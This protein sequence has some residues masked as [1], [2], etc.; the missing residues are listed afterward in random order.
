MLDDGDGVG[1]AGRSEGAGQRAQNQER[2]HTYALRFAGTTRSN[3]RYMFWRG[4]K[5]SSVLCGHSAAIA[6]LGYSQ[7]Q[8]AN[9]V[10]F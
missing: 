8:S 3:S 6:I 7:P 10:S 4:G 5:S 1:A 9:D 2:R